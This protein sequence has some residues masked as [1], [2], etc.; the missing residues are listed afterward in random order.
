MKLVDREVDIYRS[1][2]STNSW[3]RLGSTVED[4]CLGEH[5]FLGFKCQVYN[6]HIMS[7]VQIASNTQIGNVHGKKVIIEK[8]GWI[9]AGVKI[10][11]GII[12]GKGTVI[13]AGTVIVD[14]I[15]PFSVVVGNPGKVIKER[16]CIKDSYPT[17]IETLEIGFHQAKMGNG[18]SRNAEGNYITAEIFTD[19]GYKIG[20]GNILIGKK[21]SGGGIYIGNNVCI[22]DENILEGFGS[23]TIGDNV[24][25]GN[26]NHILS[27]GHNYTKLSLPRISLP[28]VIESGVTIGNNVTILGELTI[29]HNTSIPDNT[30]VMSNYNHKLKLIKKEGI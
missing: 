11:E 30:L 13:G 12:I 22:G 3:I 16:S 1:N 27:N 24:S 25:M 14:D 15:P 8:G 19:S 10:K 29:P 9:G 21:S 6:A 18:I 7:H 20:C 26:C 5:V 4:S 17:F 23:I 2:I 28:V